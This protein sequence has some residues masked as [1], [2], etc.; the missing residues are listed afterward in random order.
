[1]FD[2]I[3]L[4]VS[5]IQ[6]STTFYTTVLATLGH[7]VLVERPDSGI[8]GYGTSLPA[9]FWVTPAS[10]DKNLP[11]PVHIAFEAK[12]KAQVDAFYEAGLKAGAKANGAPGPRPQYLPDIY[13]CFLLDADGYNIECR[14]HVPSA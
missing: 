10:P 14:C 4:H 8:R 6:T 5:D 13:A 11:G 2:H 7:K 1:M 9:K 3:L 12:D